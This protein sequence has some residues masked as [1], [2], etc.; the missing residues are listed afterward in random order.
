MNLSHL[1]SEPGIYLWTNSINGKVYVGKSRNLR[2]RT[3][4]HIAALR[5]K[6]DPCS[7][8][9][10]AVNKYG[11]ES[12]EVEILMNL[13]GE[14]E[15]LEYLRELLAYWEEFYVEAFQSR[16]NGYNLLTP[17]VEVTK[18]PTSEETRQ[19]LSLARKGKPGIPHTEEFK[20]KVSEST[21]GT[22]WYT[23]GI[24]DIRL[25]LDQ[26][27]PE[28][29]TPG[30]SFKAQHSE[31]SR[32]KLSEA[33][34]GKSRGPMSQTWKD[35]LSARTKGSKWYTNGELDIRVRFEQ[36]IPE[37]FIP[38]HSFHP[39]EFRWYTNGEKNIQISLDQKA[40][41]GFTPGRLSKK[42][43]RV[44]TDPA[45]EGILPGRYLEC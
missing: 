40:P 14:S 45:P 7:L 6:D 3:L 41:D 25:K 1:P 22:K 44:E 16:G 23:D 30:H 27:I 8:L 13:E 12:F 11:L 29:F 34:K 37:G 33:R 9:Q 32:Q 28:G 17:S 10:R 4:N 24:R 26:E 35:G 39:P 18:P 43:Y 15:D 36:E 42:K 21:K 20:Q 19:K 31:E 38:G 2:K 5:R